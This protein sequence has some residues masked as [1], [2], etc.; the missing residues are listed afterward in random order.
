ML[1]ATIRT[2]FLHYS[3]LKWTWKKIF[4]WFVGT[5]CFCSVINW[6]LYSYS[7]FVFLPKY[8]Y[9]S[10]SLSWRF[11]TYKSNMHLPKFS[12]PCLS[13][14]WIETWMFFV[15]NVKSLHF[16]IHNASIEFAF[17]SPARKTQW[18]DRNFWWDI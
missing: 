10:L 14:N 17:W 2:S 11:S 6:S 9:A 12:G 7:T 4:L 5:N 18:C 15:K 16:I 3:L 8:M 1:W 13:L